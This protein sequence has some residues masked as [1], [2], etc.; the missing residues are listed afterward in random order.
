MGSEPAPTTT[1]SI[2]RTVRESDSWWNYVDSR[3]RS[4]ENNEA[5]AQAANRASSDAFAAHMKNLMRAPTLDVDVVSH[6]NL[7][8]ASCCHFSPAASPT[9]LSLEDYERD[10][11]K[12]A[13]I[14]GITT[15][16]NAIVLMGGEPL[17][18]PEL[19]E[20]VRTTRRHLPEATLWMT[21]NGLL[22][23]RMGPEFW[24]AMRSADCKLVLALYPTGLDYEALVA[25]ARAHGVRTGISGGVTEDGTISRFL[26]TPLDE[27]GLQ[28]P[29]ASFNRCPLGG[30]SLQ[31]LDGKI[32]PCNRGALLGIANER[33]GTSFT[34]DKDDYLELDA[35]RSVEDIDT[36]RRR[37]HPMCRYCA[38]SLDER[39][40]WRRSAVERDEWLMRPD[41]KDAILVL[42]AEI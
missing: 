2:V 27:E 37:A 25:L 13:R 21:S 9:F 12:L 4:G 8:C 24:D 40:E 17:L 16:F 7:N 14:E 15:L 1:P 11:E 6:C 39:I 31:L 34:H 30:F 18:H 35:I 41:E 3:D 26:R 23:K 33:F 20:L 29:T 38:T 42:R 32:F 10:L 19:P 28:D 22:L 5:G 36:M